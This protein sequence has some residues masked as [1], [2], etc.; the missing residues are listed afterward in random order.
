[1]ETFFT[2]PWARGTAFYG[3][4]WWQASRQVGSLSACLG[5]CPSMPGS[6]LMGSQPPARLSPHNLSRTL[7]PV[8]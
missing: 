5:P 3:A 2:P 1:M 7:E 4:G 6:S 8:P